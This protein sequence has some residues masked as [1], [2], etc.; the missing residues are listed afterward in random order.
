MTDRGR[1]SRAW[2][3]LES[4]RCKPVV[5]VLASLVLGYAITLLDFSFELIAPPGD[6]VEIVVSQIAPL[7]FDLAFELLPV[8]FN[9]IP[10]HSTRSFVRRGAVRIPSAPRVEYQLV[11]LKEVPVGSFSQINV[12]PDKLRNYFDRHSFLITIIFLC[13]NRGRRDE[14]EG[15]VDGKGRQH[16]VRS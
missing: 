3:A 15:A 10:I 13:R 11:I 1:H 16:K 5:D 6:L 14:N 7:L 4:L 12:L 8:P 2:N 9:T